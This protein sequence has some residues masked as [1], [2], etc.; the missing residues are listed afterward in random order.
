MKNYNYYWIK[1]SFVL[2]LIFSLM[3][4]AV[5]Q[6]T[7]YTYK[8]GTWNDIDTWTTDPGGTTL[9]GSALPTN[10][11]A[12][13]IL[14]S[15]TVTLT[16]DTATTTLD[17]TINSGGTL[18]IGDNSFTSG[19]TALRGE[20]ILRLSSANFPAATTNT[21]VQTGGGTTEY[22][23]S[24]N[25][26]LLA[27]Q[28]E[29]NNLTLDLSTT[30]IIA[31]QL[32]NITLNGDLLVKVGI[33]RINDDSGNRRQLTING[34]VTVNSG[35]SMTVGTGVTNTTTDPTGISGGSAPF[36]DY[37][38]AQSHRVAIYGD[39][40]NNGTV[41]FTNLTYPVY[42]AFPP[43]TL[44]TTTGF[45][46]VYFLGSTDNT[47]TCNS[48][49]DFYNLVV[50]KG[51]D[52]TFQLAVNS[53]DYPNFR[54]F[55]ANTSGGENGG[56]NPLLKKALWLR[57]GT[58]RLYGKTVIP[59]LSEGTC[60]AGLSGGPESDYFIPANAAL[61][62]DGPDVIV[63]TTADD[64]TEVNAAYGTAGAS[65]A[66]MGV[67]SSADCSSFSILGK[68]QIDDGYISARESGGFIYWASSSGEFIINGGTLDA[69]QFRT[70]NTTGG[71]TA[72]RQTGGTFNLRGRIKNDVSG[73]SAVADLTTVPLSTTQSTGGIQS[74]VGTFNID[75]DDNIFEMTDGTIKIYDVCGISGGIS[76]AYEVNCLPAY[77][78][79]S[80]GEVQIIPTAGTDTDYD[81]YI[82]SSA[83]IYNLT[84][85]D[86][87]VSGTF[88]VILTNIPEKV[89]YVTERLNPPLTISNDLTLSNNTTLN[90]NNYEVQVGG[91]FDLAS[92]SIY[93]PGTNKTTFNGAGYQIFTGNGTITSGLYKLNINKSADTL[94]FEGI[95][96]TYTIRDSLEIYGGVLDDG[97]K[98][99][100]VAG[101]IYNAGEH[102]GTGKILLNGTG[103]QTLE[104]S[105]FSSPTLGN[106]ELSNGTDPGAQ[107]ISDFTASTLTLTANTGGLSIFDIQDYRLTLTGGVVQTSGT[108]AFGD[109]KMVR[110]SG[111]SS[112]KG[113]KVS[114]S[115]NGAGSPDY[116]FPIGV[117][118]S[119]TNEYNPYT[120]LTPGDPGTTTGTINVVPVNS[121]HPTVKT[122]TDV[123]QFYWKVDASGFVGATAAGFQ[124]YFAYFGDITANQQKAAYLDYESVDGWI[125]ANG[126]ADKNNDDITF[127]TGL[128]F[129]STDFTAGKQAAFNKP[130]I[131]YSRASTDWH[132]AS[133]WSEAAFGG[134]IAAKAPETYDRFIIG[135]AAG[136]NH[137]VD[138]N[139]G[140]LATIAGVEIYS[141]AATGI[142]GTPPTL[143]NPAG[144]TGVNLTSVSGGGR[145]VQNDDDLP[146]GDFGDFCNNDTAIFEY[147]TGTY[148]I[149]TVI[150]VYPNL[151]ITSN[152]VDMVKTLPNSSILVQN[153]LVLSTASTGN[154]LRFNSAGGD[155]T[156]YNDVALDNEANLEFDGASVQNLNIYGDLDLDYDDSGTSTN[157]LG[158]NT[159]TAAHKIN[160]YGDS[161]IIGA[162]AINVANG[163]LS[164]LDSLNTVIPNGTGS[165]TL[166]KLTINKNNLT[167]TV[168]ISED[169]T[170]NGTTNSS[171]KA[172]TLSKGTLI[173]ENTSTDVEL[174]SSGDFNIPQ[175]SALIL[176]DGAS[177]NVIGSNAGIFLDGLLSA[178]ST[179][180]INLG[181]GSTGDTRYIE[182][183][184]SG[185]AEIILTES[186]SLT[187]N[188]QIRRSL[189]QTNGVLKFNQSG[190]ASTI[191][192]GRGG[193][194]TRSRF[195]VVNPGS[196]F[197]MTGGTFTIIRGGGTTYGDLFLRPAS[198]EATGGTITLGSVDVG[199]QTIKFD[200]EIALNTLVLDGVASMNTFQI[201]VNPLVMNGDLTINTTNSTLYA[202]GIDVT[203]KGDLTNNGT[204]TPG[205][206]TTTFDGT[207]QS[208]LGSTVTDFYNLVSEPSRTLT[209]NYDVTIA[210]DL[211]INS[212]TLITSTYDVLV[213][214]D[215]VNNGV[216]S[217]NATQGGLI[218]NGTVEQNISGTGKFGR[219]NLYN[220]NGARILN[221]ISLEQD[222]LLS[223]G[224]FNINQYLLTLSENANIVDTTGA[225]F[226]S[227]KMIEPNGVFSNVGIKKSFFAV[228]D[229]ITYPLGIS[230]KYTP[231]ILEINTSAAGSVRI[232]TIN[233]NHPT[234]VD[235]TEVLQYYWEVEC[236]DISGFD[237]DLKFKYDNG[238]VA[239]TEADYVAAR[240]VIP[241]GTTWS[242]ATSGS[243]ETDNVYEATDTIVFDFNGVDNLSGEYTAGAD[244][245]IPATVPTF[246][247]N[248]DG[249]WDDV[250]I[251]TPVA[252]AG[253]PNGFIVV[254]NQGDSVNTNGNRRFAYKTTING[255]LDVEDS[256]G[257]NLGT[258]D[259]TGKLR[260]EGPILPA[261]RFTSFISCA[262]GILE[263]NGSTDYTIIADRI[264]TIRG[265]Y[266][267]G[268]G[269]RILPDKD[270][271]ICDTLKISGAT[272]DN[273][274]NKRNLTINGVFQRLNSGKFLSGS[275]DATVIF[276]GSSPQTLGGADG[277]FTGTNGFNNFEINNSSGL[278]LNSPLEINKTLTLTDGII[279]TTSTNIL[280]MI[281]DGGGDADNIVMPTAGGSSSSYVDGPMSKYISGGKDFTFPIGDGS[282]YG[283]VQTL[284]VNEG[285]WKAEYFDVGHATSSVTGGLTAVSI[286]EYWA[287]TNPAATK[288][289]QVKLRWDSSSDITPLTTT[290]GIND[291]VVAEFDGSDWTDIASDAP[292]GDDYDGTVTT[293][294]TINIDPMYYT[295]GSTSAILA[296]AY[297]TVLDD[298]CEGT[299]IPV[300]FSG[301]TAGE[302]NYI[303]SYKIGVTPQADVTI[304]AADLPYSLPTSITGSGNYVLTGFSYNNPGSP[305]AGTIDGSAVTV[306]AV[307]AQPTI[308]AVGEP[309]SL[310]FCDGGS[311]I[312]TSS[313]GTTYLWS[314]GATTQNISA[315][316]SGNYTVQVTGVGGCL[317]LA[318]APKTVV[319]NPVPI[320][321]L[322]VTAGLEERCDGD[323]T[324][325]DLSFTAGTGPWSFTISDGTDT[326]NGTS[327][328]D[329][330]YTPAGAMIP[331][332]E[333]GAPYTT[334]TYSITLVTDANACTNTGAN[335]VDVIVHKVP[336]T[337]NT[338]APPN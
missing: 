48:T 112:A 207:T 228:A 328:A 301:V 278:T 63:L 152:A 80:G 295:L 172:L 150:T 139:D 195:E 173:L 121:Y 230:G 250:N 203:L 266:F 163:T 313:A 77:Y 47:L 280:K 186:A 111:A 272:L 165:I 190:S 216:H 72:Y 125:T 59:S 38:D 229:T 171:P 297:F 36:I 300:S 296:K 175:T 159:G 304:T 56:S 222:L 149:P 46:T 177:V 19:L 26:T 264:D 12:V 162:S 108:L 323:N 154:T 16:N 255:I 25:F 151:H 13:V 67:N 94:I 187:V 7:Y 23:N 198:G 244:A 81:Y 40:T 31:T 120:L 97:G 45:A 79:V 117:D 83:P 315:I 318:S 290:G 105:V 136:V 90:S 235:D 86:S 17:I 100:N 238:D 307:P 336:E 224:V 55:G 11:D 182:Y 251:W 294:N 103:T 101:N 183:S 233:D 293:T 227:T 129:L 75:R 166:N 316:T 263:Y 225:G 249:D 96:A 337:G 268:T 41:R 274:V 241:D 164:I 211:S 3:S 319:V 194:A 325:I 58:L 237:G 331:I 73:V 196:E 178:D 267:T 176:K 78:S 128:G 20:G 27:T 14:M 60:D 330:P 281:T 240:L 298:V 147:S 158:V 104:A 127:N 179:S 212:D 269:K 333:G 35:S 311:V 107:L 88:N 292:V 256:Y 42:D 289:A 146:S 50:D 109:D 262:G 189:S 124:Y 61:V 118:D 167:D 155:L 168:K 132:L 308:S 102:T 148:D 200:S 135:G 275:N 226:S 291:I 5:G 170:L 74:A 204:Y 133:T 142:S 320:V 248:S 21:F 66:A 119:G 156:V 87:N 327:G 37:Y 214:G 30:S 10:G 181:D 8:S 286:T 259:G 169:F 205:T 34:D 68:F 217:G 192:Y 257:H 43:T 110:T 218:L 273:S 334:T 335:T 284:G 287:I 137:I 32:S 310:T 314:T 188:S 6:T 51:T 247:S 232:N 221:A 134:A 276:A 123:I 161:V 253:G 246:T 131:L 206:N 213:A 209:F 143:N 122:T 270:L 28:T 53:S 33:Y 332:W 184:G 106:I 202:N 309:G 64:Y 254:I 201:M 261:G 191:I 82:A 44:G 305:T 326:Y 321:S 49:T 322:A 197:N 62:I 260:L 95:P 144:N 15:R 271:V 174:S 89:G 283:V 220:P 317:S 116:L 113:L 160:F 9:V 69:K 185:N 252:P 1:I 282:R 84:I 234:V 138:I 239:G 265:I 243:D 24:S 288:A 153:E 126:S 303:L 114:I 70:A 180:T 76:R 52:Q 145:Y 71:L 215:I 302:L 338:F 4:N 279:T 199:V 258:V 141:S 277:E 193:S 22:Y 99:L 223:D 219:L 242:K 208:I 98:T 306:N 312:L 299:A 18:D 39:F 140:G 93:T 29:Y 2:V 130:R 324:E 115:L 157:T 245:A 91:D 65:N 54:L 57:N 231:A 92:T 85:D 210:N 236:S 329:D 285:T